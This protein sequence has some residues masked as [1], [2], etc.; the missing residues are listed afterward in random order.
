M[1][2]N[3]KLI[4]LSTISISLLAIGCSS[5]SI[6]VNKKDIVS[7]RTASLETAPLETVPLATVELE[8]VQLETASLEPIPLETAQIEEV[9]R[10]SAFLSVP[11]LETAPHSVSSWKSKLSSNNSRGSECVGDKCVASIGQPQMSEKSDMVVGDETI[12]PAEDPYFAS[13]V[14]VQVGAFRK[15][16]GAQNYAKRYALL[17]SQYSVNIKKD[18]KDFEP[19]Y[20][21]QIKG[22]ASNDDAENFINKYGSQGA[23]LVR[24]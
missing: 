5:K 2:I 15:I 13:N 3:K 24:K 17:D 7:Y 10:K 4:L 11:K 22:F 14:A 21:V 16:S 6:Q 9:E 19:I 12:T 1:K 20:R 8:T 23:F 18:I